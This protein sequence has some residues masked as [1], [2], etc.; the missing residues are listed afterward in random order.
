MPNLKFS[1]F[2]EQTDPDNV[3]F[4]VGYNGSDNVRIAPSNV[5]DLS[6]YLPLTG[7]EIT[8]NLSISDDVGIGTISPSSKLHVSGGDIRLDFNERLQW[9]NGNTRI[10]GS[11]DT[12][13]YLRA[14]LGYFF[15]T[16]GGYRLVID[17]N[18]GNVGI[19]TSGPS[20]K[21][22]VNGNITL[23]DFNFSQIRGLY[24]WN[25]PIITFNG[26][27]FDT[28]I[29]S[30]A[31]RYNPI[32]AQM[33]F[34]V[35]GNNDFLSHDGGTGETVFSYSGSEKMRIEG[36]GNVGI[37]T[38]SPTEKLEVNG[39]VRAS[40]FYLASTT[41]LIQPAFGT[42]YIVSNNGSRFADTSGTLKPVTASAFNTSSDYRL[43]SNIVPLEGAIS[44]LNQL[45]VHR[46]N[47]NN[48]L[49]EPKVDGFIAHE[50]APIIP[51][52]VLG[53]K[54]GTHP[55]GTPD[56]QGIDQ[57][58]IVP[59]LTAALQEA[60]TKIENLENRIQILENK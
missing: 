15:E 14:T 38:T 22:D 55:D 47:W 6:A 45:E 2:L 49:D 27:T 59:L 37:G 33:N 54:D 25:G 30:G 18:S 43:K 48:R 21:L 9:D 20:T 3:Q 1:Q 29:A 39:N 51:E 4:L 42:I 56:Y 36:S 23:S 19:G 53:E 46:F 16:N 57:S 13:M 40:K 50:V 17:G 10:I 31:I 11:S 44:R 26:T 32:V 41:Q 28:E 60:I 8:G 58:K 12:R 5:A 24:G 35:D 7:G 34:K 52:A